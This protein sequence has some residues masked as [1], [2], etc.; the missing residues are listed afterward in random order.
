MHRLTIRQ[1]HNSQEPVSHL[2]DRCPSTN[3]SILLHRFLH[4]ATNHSFNS[5]ITDERTIRPLSNELEIFGSVH[6]TVS[7]PCLLKFLPKQVY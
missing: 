6:R 1:Q 5:F 7:S 3:P 4:W 2:F